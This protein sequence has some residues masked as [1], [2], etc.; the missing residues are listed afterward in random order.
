MRSGGRQYLGN[1]RAR[2][3][4]EAKGFNLSNI[5]LMEILISKKANNV[6]QSFTNRENDTHNYLMELYKNTI[7]KIEQSTKEIEVYKNDKPIYRETINHQTEAEFRLKYIWQC[8]QL[9]VNYNYETKT[10]TIRSDIYSDKDKS[11]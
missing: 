11:K 5:R 8:L 4:K 9:N 7:D 6:I 2:K 10:I 3:R 1:L